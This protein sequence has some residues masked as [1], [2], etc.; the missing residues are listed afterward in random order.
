V[1]PRLH[2]VTDDGILARGDFP[3]RAREALEAGGP[4]L[5]L[6]LRGPGTT[7]RTLFSL[8]ADLLGPAQALGSLLLVNDRVDVALSLGLPGVH[9]GQR[10]LPPGAARDLLGPDRVLGLSAHSL[11]EAQE[12]RDGGVDFLMLGTIFPTPS[13][14]GGE[15]GGVARI[16]EVGGQVSLPLVAIGG[17]NPPRVQAVVE[18]GAHGVAVRGGAWE[19][20]EMGGAV[21]AFLEALDASRTLG[22][23]SQESTTKEEEDHP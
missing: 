12:A 22:P 6:H 11:R 20:P 7:G 5:A 19:A 21:G 17:M 3:A 1:I 2:L 8:A 23:A 4:R 14:P 9:L 18:A 13:H 15:V 10:S 16:M